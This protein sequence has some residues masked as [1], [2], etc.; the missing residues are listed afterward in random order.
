MKPYLFDHLAAVEDVIR[1]GPFGLIVDVDGT[2]APIAPSPELAKVAPGCARQLR[3]LS[4]L[5]PLVAAISGR[6]AREARR[7]VGLPSVVYMGNHGIERWERR[8]V[9]TDAAAAGFR[10]PIRKAL[11]RLQATVD[12]PG[13]KIEDKG[14]TLSIHYREAANCETARKVALAAARS[15]AVGEGLRVTEG[16][17]VVEIRPP[18]EIDK[19]TAVMRLIGDYGIGSAVYLGDDMTDVDAFAALRRWR[20]VG[21]GK[22]L[23]IAVVSAESPELLF[24]ETD[25]FANGVADVERFLTWLVRRWPKA[26]GPSWKD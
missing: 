12:S 1:D 3:V 21:A 17:M 13:V 7:M 8:R 10:A 6:P 11:R 14:I 5:L 25:A 4:R 22:S 26:D 2:I 9:V 23:S 24:K 19:G 16:R 18:V 20:K 15:V